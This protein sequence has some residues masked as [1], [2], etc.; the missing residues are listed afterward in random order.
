MKRVEEVKSLLGAGYSY[1]PYTCWWSNKVGSRR[2]EILPMRNSV[3][4]M[5]YDGIKR[6]NDI[7]VV[8]L[9]EAIEAGDRWLEAGD[10]E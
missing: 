3:H 10:A 6:E 9:A 2:T 1:N 5:M 8:T 4:A 7:I